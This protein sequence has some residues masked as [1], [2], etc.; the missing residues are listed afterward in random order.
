MGLHVNRLK[1]RQSYNSDD[2]EEGR[3]KF[4]RQAISTSPDPILD[5][6]DIRLNTFT[7]NG[8]E[9]AIPERT[10][11]VSFFKSNTFDPS[12]ASSSW[13]AAHEQYPLV[14]IDS[15]GT[16]DGTETVNIWMTEIP[17]NDSRIE[18]MIISGAE[19]PNSAEVSGVEEVA[20]ID[21]SADD[22]M[23]EVKSRLLATSENLQSVLTDP[24]LEN[25]QEGRCF[26]QTGR[27][28]TSVVTEGEAR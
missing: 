27:S 6:P 13:D 23:E 21:W 7:P 26:L 3:A 19:L 16:E 4:S 18:I 22:D 9:I 28:A 1:R 2:E 24:V 8:S 15:V 10:T 5:V 17:E 11:D 14:W 20:F 12:N 25:L